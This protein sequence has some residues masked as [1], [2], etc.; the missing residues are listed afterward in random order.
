MSGQSVYQNVYGSAT[1]PNLDPYTQ[2][3]L[4]AAQNSGGAT[5]QIAAEMTHPNGGFMSTA[6]EKL[7][8]SFHKLMDTLAIPEDGVTALMSQFTDDPYSFERVRKERISP[9]D[10]LWG[11]FPKDMNLAQKVG[12]GGA[13]FITDVLLDPLTYVTFGAGTGLKSI[14]GIQKLLKIP[15]GPKAAALLGYSES[16]LV[17]V[18]GGEEL[19][20]R[21]ALSPVGSEKYNA[22]MQHL[23]DRKSRDVLETF[24]WDPLTGT[25]KNAPGVE[26]FGLNGK[27]GAET[28]YA[29]NI[30]GRL[31][32]TTSELAGKSEA[33]MAKQLSTLAQ[34]GSSGEF[35]AALKLQ[36][37]A[38][39]RGLATGAMETL[40]PAQR[41][42]WRLASS[43]AAK[44]SMNEQAES[45]IRHT[46]SAKRADIEEE[47]AQSMRKLIEANAKDGK[48]V[49]SLGRPVLDQFGNQMVRNYAKEFIDKGGVKF[50]GQ[51]VISGAR[52]RTALQLLTPAAEYMRSLSGVGRA[53]Q[54]IDVFRNTAFSL[55]NPNYN[56]GGAI[57]ETMQKILAQRLNMK[58]AQSLEFEQAVETIARRLALTNE[59][60]KALSWMLAADVPPSGSV[61]GKYEKMFSL[62]SSKGGTEIAQ[63]I[64]SGKHGDDPKRIWKALTALRDIENRSLMAAHESGLRVF[65]QKNHVTNMFN[66]SSPVLRPGVRTQSSQ[67]VNAEKAEY[68]KFQ[69]VN[70]PTEIKYGD[71]DSLELKRFNKVEE[72]NRIQEYLQ[73]TVADSEARTKEIHAEIE[74]VWDKVS[75]KMTEAIMGPAR[76]VFFSIAAHDKTTLKALDEVF[77]EAIPEVD[78]VRVLKQYVKD[79]YKNGV[80]LRTLAKELT[81][82]DLNKLRD[83][84]SVGNPE[85]DSIAKELM[86]QIGDLN[87]TKI[88]PAKIPTGVKQSPDEYQK[89]L[90]EMQDIIRESALEGRKK[91]LKEA[92]QQAPMTA[93]KTGTIEAG[94]AAEGSRALIIPG[95]TDKF[96]VDSMGD[97]LSG[98]SEQWHKNPG[99]VGRLLEEVLGKDFQ[100]RG[101]MEDLA[102]VKKGL[103]MEL[104][105]PGLKKVGGQLFYKDSKGN[106]FEQKRA[107]AAS[108]NQV[109]HNGDERYIEDAL[110]QV[111]FGSINTIRVVNS[112]YLMNDVAKYF[113]VTKD[114]APSNYVRVGVEQLKKKN[115]DMADFMNAGA[116]KGL[117]FA[118]DDLYFHPA[119]AHSILDTMEIMQRD[120]ASALLLKGFDTFTNLWKASVTS[121]FPMFHGRNALSNVWQNFMT[122]GAEAI[123]PHTHY[124]SFQMLKDAKRLDNL[125]ADVVDGINPE[126]FKQ[127][128][129]LYKKPMLTDSTGYTWTVGEINRVVRDNALAFN[130]RN[131]GNMDAGRSSKEMLSSIEDPVFPELTRYMTPKI[132]VLKNKLNTNTLTPFGMGKWV[133]NVIEDQAKLVNFLS[134]LRQTGN[135]EHAALLT[136]Q[137]LFDYQNLTSFERSTLRRIIPFYTY[138]RKNLELM[139]KTLLHNPGRVDMF[140]NTIQN[141]GDV[142]AGG[143]Q[144]SDEERDMLPSWM[145]DGLSIVL[146]RNGDKVDLLSSLATPLEQ[147]FQAASSLYGSL[148]PLIKTPIETSTGYSF[149]YGKPLSQVTDATLFT[150]APDS[151]KELIGFTQFSYKDKQ[152]KEHT[153]Y[154]SL[155]P[156]YMN[157]VMS[158]PLVP[159]VLNTI[160]TWDKT[161]PTSIQGINENLFGVKSQDIDLDYESKQRQKEMQTQLEELLQNANLG[162]TFKRF[163]LK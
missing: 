12:V 38:K 119:V 154:I 69:N 106:I 132:N 48:I 3:L 96:S 78:R 9:S 151:L 139:G 148:N 90:K 4:D 123:N 7:G 65:P 101:L 143:D 94:A 98:L 131:V 121:I 107:A 130:P 103:E 142:A 80:R 115:P 149:F 82:D 133:G 126:S 59:D 34:Q 46:L 21:L 16:S 89:A 118:G 49:D 157:L 95:K 28:M 70:D 84:L 15:L 114:A 32:R 137:S 27:K 36:E 11:K 71:S 136:R 63:D 91:Y 92:L 127:M 47:V 62:F 45:L 6:L 124:L 112:R 44:T 33:D 120:P 122:I 2:Q 100:I 116:D 153:R 140:R 73:K 145:K 54:S 17:K 146:S 43:Q 22:L 26:V 144:L 41:D 1:Q 75:E 51:A 134:N 68:N 109:L 5:A 87:I 19:A 29:N 10:V 42:A 158:M 155:D 74:G 79:N 108:L 83:D 37:I 76:K 150:Y 161:P 52:I 66:P 85:L 113:G 72:R 60:R 56:V 162:Y 31:T 50:F 24:G 58:E 105:D 102:D 61:D 163:Q 129:D 64:L 93:K 99:P 86:S 159:R 125:A 14:F 128:L 20:K 40:T 57:P 110:T 88:K 152:G 23:M 77:T 55:V 39:E 30:F 147:P 18:A 141:I 53:M 67:A 35:G 104:N 81:T 117:G 97:I 156:V 111:K 160:K 13:R 8:S 138:T 135:V 25:V